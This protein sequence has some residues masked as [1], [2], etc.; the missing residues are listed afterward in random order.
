MLNTGQVRN[1][2]CACMAISWCA[3]VSAQQLS[4][5]INQARS[6]DWPSQLASSTNGQNSSYS[7][8]ADGSCQ[9]VIYTSDAL[10]AAEGQV[11]PSSGDLR[12][13]LVPLQLACDDDLR[14]VWSS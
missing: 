6:R 4:H 9:N 2:I 12:E 14:A 8:F 10:A 5:A 1:G 7:Q 3:S 11:D 13:D